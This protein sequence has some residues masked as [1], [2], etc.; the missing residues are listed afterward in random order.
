MDE[1]R[2]AEKLEVK[3]SELEIRVII[4]LISLYLAII[5]FRQWMCSWCAR[6]EKSEIKVLADFLIFTYI[7][8]NFGK[9]WINPFSLQLWVKIVRHDYSQDFCCYFH[10]SFVCASNP[11]YFFWHVYCLILPLKRLCRENVIWKELFDWY[12]KGKLLGHKN[13]WLWH[14]WEIMTN[15]LL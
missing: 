7:R 13:A 1:L 10:P 5:H 2:W 9:E 4:P 14:F 12:C 6:D 3:K 15:K 11:K 8:I